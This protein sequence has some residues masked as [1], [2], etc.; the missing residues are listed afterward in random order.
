MVIPL[1]CTSNNFSRHLARAHRTL[2]NFLQVKLGRGINGHFLL[3]GHGDSIFYYIFV[4][5][6]A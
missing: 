5:L 2:R 4:M 3:N 1:N 6:I